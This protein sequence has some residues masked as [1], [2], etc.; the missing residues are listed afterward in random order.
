MSKGL[1]WR[2]RLM[3]A[4]IAKQTMREEG[5]VKLVDGRFV[6]QSFP[7]PVA[8]RSIDYGAPGKNTDADWHASFTARGAWNREQAMRRAL[9]SLE[10]R[11]LVKLGSY[12]FRPEAADNVEIEFVYCHPDR[13]IPGETRWMTGATLT[14]AGWA[15]IEAAKSA[16]RADGSGDAESADPEQTTPTAKQAIRRPADAIQERP[17]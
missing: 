12:A 2:Q 11:G 4:S 1:S 3:L 14:E 16:A 7:R 8:W 5:P 6:R 10:R 17:K 13:Y 15:A 9:R